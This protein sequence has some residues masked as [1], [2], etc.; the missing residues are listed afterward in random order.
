VAK[1]FWAFAGRAPADAPLDP[2][3]EAGHHEAPAF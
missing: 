2:R 3:S 1:N